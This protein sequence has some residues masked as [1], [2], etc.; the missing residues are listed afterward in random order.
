MQASN[1]IVKPGSRKRV[2][3][4][5]I[6]SLLLELPYCHRII[7]GIALPNERVKALRVFL[8]NL[9]RIQAPGFVPVSHLFDRLTKFE[10]V[11]EEAIDELGRRD[12]GHDRRRVPAARTRQRLHFEQVA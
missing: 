3:A 5:F 1:S 7:F 12:E 8:L 10:E 4:I 9:G 6:P 11:L 2:I